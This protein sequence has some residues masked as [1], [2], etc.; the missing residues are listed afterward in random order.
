[1]NIDLDVERMVLLLFLADH[2]GRWVRLPTKNNR[3]IRVL[4]Y[5]GLVWGRVFDGSL[6]D[7]PRGDYIAQRLKKGSGWTHPTR[8]SLCDPRYETLTPQGWKG[9]EEPT[10]VMSWATADE[11][12]LAFYSEEDAIWCFSE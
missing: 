3:D 5:G 6:L 7:I 4:A 9:L 11:A 12:I 2:K 1:M 10:E 8:A